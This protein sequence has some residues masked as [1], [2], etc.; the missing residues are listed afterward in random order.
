MP[1]GSQA[2]RNRTLRRMKSTPL[3]PALGD[4]TRAAR[5]CKY[6]NNK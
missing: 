1:H 2:V 3:E 4:P 5:V 6:A